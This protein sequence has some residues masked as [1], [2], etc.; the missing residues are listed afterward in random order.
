ME[1]LFFNNGTLASSPS[2]ISGLIKFC[3][4]STS[5]YTFGSLNGDIVSLKRVYT[6][7]YNGNNVNFTVDTTNLSMNENIPTNNPAFDNVLTKSID[8]IRCSATSTDEKGQE[9]IGKGDTFYVCIKPSSSDGALED[10][11]L[12]AFYDYDL[13]DGEYESSIILVD[14]NAPTI[15]VVQVSRDGD[16]WRIAVPI[17]ALFTQGSSDKF[18][19]QGN[20]NVGFKQNGANKTSKMVDTT[21]RAGFGIEVQMILGRE[22]GCLSKLFKMVKSLFF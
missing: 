1:V 17:L 4:K 18:S 19:L 13:S 3:L 5:I 11:N 15:S 14:A 21:N 6:I 12:L 10:V 22:Y 16:W 7:R 2:T 8:A 20:A 9:A